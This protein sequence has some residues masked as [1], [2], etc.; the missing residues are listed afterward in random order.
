MLKITFGR[1]LCNNLRPAS[2]RCFKPAVLAP[3]REKV[4]ISF[5]VKQFLGMQPCNFGRPISKFFSK[6]FV[7]KLTLLNNS[8]HQIIFSGT[9]MRRSIEY[10]VFLTHDPFIYAAF[11]RLLSSLKLT[12][13]PKNVTFRKT[14][15]TPWFSTRVT[16]PDLPPPPPP[17]PS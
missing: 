16:P 2:T 6:T 4:S 10:S 7:S 3:A 15:H 9:C 11:C 12:A 13:H 8:S 17:V 14:Q 5:S 1:S